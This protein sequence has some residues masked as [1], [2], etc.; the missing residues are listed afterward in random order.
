[1]RMRLIDKRSYQKKKPFRD[2]TLFV[3]VCEGERTEPNYFKFFDR[4]T[5]RVKVE[6]VPSEDG[7]SAPKHLIENARKAAA[8]IEAGGDYELWIILDMDAWGEAQIREVLK[9]VRDQGSWQVAISNPCFEVWLFNHFMYDQTPEEHNNK[10][11]VWKKALGDLLPS[12]FDFQLHPS[13]LHL[14]IK[15]SKDTYEE[16]GFLPKLSSTQVFRLG[17]RLYEFCKDVLPT[18]TE[19]KNQ[20]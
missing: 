9:R 5:K 8:K 13:H 16:E 14:A 3:V 1:M 2:A 11:Q 15:Q 10:C 18:H 17:E 12:G 7:K 19:I 20:K 4:L 6:P